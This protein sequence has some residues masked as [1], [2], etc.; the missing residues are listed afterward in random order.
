MT[1]TLATTTAA[2]IQTSLPLSLFPFLEIWRDLLDEPVALVSR[3]GVVILELG[4]KREKAK[5]DVWR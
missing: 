1:P 4:E 3:S 5:E 2:V